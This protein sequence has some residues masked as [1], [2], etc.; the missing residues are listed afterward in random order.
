MCNMSGTIKVLAEASTRHPF[1][2]VLGARESL[3]ALS[4][5]REE[6]SAPTR[7]ALGCT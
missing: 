5:C 4:V 3:L 6:P 2:V 1:A 7:E